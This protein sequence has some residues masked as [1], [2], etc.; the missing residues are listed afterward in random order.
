MLDAKEAA[1]QS[2]A[3]KERILKQNVNYLLKKCEQEIEDYIKTGHS[4]CKVDCSYVTDGEAIQHVVDYLKTLG[5]K[6]KHLP[7]SHRNFP[8][9]I[10]IEWRKW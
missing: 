10:Q 4:E 1:T 9:N 8:H 7:T 5:Y 6:T 3:N 2:A